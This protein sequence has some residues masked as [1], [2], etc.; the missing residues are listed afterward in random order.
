M[1]NF[2]RVI[3]ILISIH[4]SNSSLAIHASENTI[5]RA[6]FSTLESGIEKYNFT[7]FQLTLNNGNGMLYLMP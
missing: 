4:F 6:E 1:L 7:G 3:L 2:K 5:K